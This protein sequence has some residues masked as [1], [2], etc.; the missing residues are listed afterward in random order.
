M[1]FVYAF[2]GHGH[3]GRAGRRLG[4]GGDRCTIDGLLGRQTISACYILPGHKRSR[5]ESIAETVHRAEVAETVSCLTAL[6]FVL[7]DIR[8]L[9]V[10]GFLIQGGPEGGDRDISVVHEDCSSGVVIW[11]C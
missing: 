1:D 8:L 5:A 11:R 4:S 9:F 10:I 2:T 6:T 7:R 3:R